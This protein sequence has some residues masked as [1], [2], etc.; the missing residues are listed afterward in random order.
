[1]N[2]PHA[3]Q[4]NLNSTIKD[5]RLYKQVIIIFLLFMLT[6]ILFGLLAGSIITINIFPNSHF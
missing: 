5:A 1:M 4:K 2:K 6:A 3:N